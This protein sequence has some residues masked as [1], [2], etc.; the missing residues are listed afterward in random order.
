[1]SD[2][3][4]PKPRKWDRK[5]DGRCC[6]ACEKEFKPSDLVYPIGACCIH[7]ECVRLYVRQCREL[8]IAP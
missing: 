8:G 6:L 3:K 1:V 7:A 2:D 5:G 4:K